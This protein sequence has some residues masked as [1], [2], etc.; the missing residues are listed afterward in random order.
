MPRGSVLDSGLCSCSIRSCCLDGRRAPLDLLPLPFVIEGYWPPIELRRQAP[1]LVPRLVAAHSG[2]E[3]YSKGLVIVGGRSRGCHSPWQV[4]PLGRYC[5]PSC[6]RR[7]AGGLG[8]LPSSW[9]WHAWERPSAL[10]WWLQFATCVRVHIQLPTTRP[11][12][13]PTCELVESRR[14]CVVLCALTP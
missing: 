12:H 10:S 6:S 2:R 13:S 14:R 1:A 8:G 9:A 4:L 3:Y 5:W 7:W 11:V